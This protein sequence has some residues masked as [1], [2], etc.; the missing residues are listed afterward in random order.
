MLLTLKGAAPLY[1]SLS[2][3][4]E[5]PINEYEDSWQLL[6]FTHINLNTLS[7]TRSDLYL[8]PGWLTKNSFEIF[9]EEEHRLLKKITLLSDK[10]V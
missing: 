3:A 10:Y 2:N 1:Q 8:R 7:S 5:D 6:A 9:Y 4:C